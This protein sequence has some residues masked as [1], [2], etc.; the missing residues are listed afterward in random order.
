MQ[1]NMRKQP[2][3]SSKVPNEVSSLLLYT[4]HPPISPS[5]NPEKF[6]R[7]YDQ[8][9]KKEDIMQNLDEAVTVLLKVVC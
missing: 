2:F 4:Q 1:D 5:D 6:S 7:W 3:Y 8:S 9:C